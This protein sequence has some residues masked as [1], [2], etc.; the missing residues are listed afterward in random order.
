VRHVQD[1][2]RAKETA[3]LDCGSLRHFDER[4]AESANRANFIGLHCEGSENDEGRLTMTQLEALQLAVS[5]LLSRR[6]KLCR[7]RKDLPYMELRTETAKAN[8][9][10]IDQKLKATEQAIV[11]LNRMSGL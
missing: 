11:L 9:A 2:A 5:V 1:D 3:G 4:M 10:E 7:K 8:T 6:A